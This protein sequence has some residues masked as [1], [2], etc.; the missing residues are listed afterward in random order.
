MIKGKER[1]L[2][3]PVLLLCTT[4]A[5]LSCPNSIRKRTPSGKGI[6]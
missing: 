6:A 4:L 5:G 3:L 1:R 2:R